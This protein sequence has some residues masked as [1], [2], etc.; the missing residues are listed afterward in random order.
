MPVCK[1]AAIASPMRKRRANIETRYGRRN[2]YGKDFA[3][4]LQSEH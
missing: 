4:V 2:Q 3:Y 1:N